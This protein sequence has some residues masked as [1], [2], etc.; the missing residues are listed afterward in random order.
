MPTSNSY[1]QLL[2][3]LSLQLKPY[4]SYKTPDI[5]QSEFTAQDL[6]N[7]VYADKIVDDFNDGKLND[8]GTPKQPSAEEQLTP[9]DAKL[10]AAQTGTDIF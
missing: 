4:V 3:F 6:F 8:D 5:V 7:V 1:T 9:E 2:N 10:K